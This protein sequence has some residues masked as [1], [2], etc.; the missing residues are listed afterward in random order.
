MDLALK[1]IILFS[2][3]VPRLAAF[4]R[5]VIGLPVIGTEEG[6][7]ELDGGAC[8]I[9]IHAGRSKVGNK[10]PKLVFHAMDVG[11]A[12]ANLILR[13]FKDLGPV[14]STAKFDMCDG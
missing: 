6:W 5:D 1:R 11:T 7:V 4:Y 12:R 3:D 9:A 8:A 2:S 10:P 13:G 14:K